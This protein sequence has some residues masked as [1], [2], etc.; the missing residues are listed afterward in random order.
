MVVVSLS[1]SLF[2][3]PIALSLSCHGHHYTTKDGNSADSDQVE[4]LGIKSETRTK[5]RIRPERQFGWE[6]E[7][8]HRN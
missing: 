1:S 8:H 6:M 3:L 4:S 7:I 5:N 2:H